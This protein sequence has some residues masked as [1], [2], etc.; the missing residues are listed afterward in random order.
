MHPVFSSHSSF[1]AHIVSH[2]LEDN[3]IET[4]VHGEYSENNG[5]HSPAG[6]IVTLCV[7][8]KRKIQKAKD[9]IND[10]QENDSE[11]IPT[12]Q[13]EKT[14]YV[15]LVILCFG[16]LLSLAIVNKHGILVQVW[17]GFFD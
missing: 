6:A 17:R 12:E 1:E 16:F 2:M 9:L 10:H 11:T 13:N 5:Y 4:A 8:D 7:L 14:K 15:G 3:G